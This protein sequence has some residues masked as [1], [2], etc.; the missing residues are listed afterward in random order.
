MLILFSILVGVP[1]A[2]APEP[3]MSCAVSSL[4]IL[5][6]FESRHLAVELLQDTLPHGTDGNSI[7]EM[8]QVSRRLGMPLVARHV[9][10]RLPNRPFIAYLWPVKSDSGAPGHFYAV[11]LLDSYS[12]QFQVIE[13]KLAPQ[14]LYEHEILANPRFSG[15]VLVV[16]PAWWQ[17]ITWVCFALCVVSVV[18]LFRQITTKSKAPTQINQ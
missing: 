13:P 10:R 6:Q 8:L 17:A 7:A 15:I 16:V 9:S 18:L 11:R 3:G 5:S 14:V 1:A 12:R 4:A 2:D